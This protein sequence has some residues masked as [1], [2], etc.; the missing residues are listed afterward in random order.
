MGALITSSLI[1]ALPS[2]KMLKHEDFLEITGK[3][4]PRS[5]H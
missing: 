5:G 1:Q 4:K 2:H 3:E